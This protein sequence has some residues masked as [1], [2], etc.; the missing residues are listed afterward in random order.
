MF[1]LGRFGCWVGK[2]CSQDML[3]LP[4]RLVE[5]ASMLL[6]MYVVNQG[7]SFSNNTRVPFFS[8]GF[9]LSVCLWIF[10]LKYC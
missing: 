3:F 4:F 10:F 9:C 7:A 1:F 5:E 8:F 2:E 6:A